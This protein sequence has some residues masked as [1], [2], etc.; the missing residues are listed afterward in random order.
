MQYPVR[1]RFNNKRTQ[2]TLLMKRISAIIPVLLSVVL[3]SASCE[4]SKMTDDHENW[5]ERNSDYIDKI[6]SSTFITDIQNA[7][8][9]QM[10]R[11]LSFKL[12]PKGSSSWGNGMYVYCKVIS[13]GTGTVTPQY[14]DSVR[15]NYRVRL[16]PTDNYP[17]G[18]V[19]D[20][21]FKTEKLDP[22]VN[23]PS[24]FCI[25]GLIDGVATAL[26][27]MRCG[28]FWQ[29]YIPYGLGYGTTDRTNIPGYSALI[30][31]INLTE[32]ARTGQDLSPR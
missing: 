21:S 10:F 7:A 26:M 2:N 20:Q 16:I 11:L 22:S 29:L 25:S 17:E 31:E 19:I 4:E 18:Q 1:H 12:D 6:A 28:D 13:K 24:S 3:F 32:I 8:P 15:V 30:Y 5:Q 27:N 14:T 23:V 9:E